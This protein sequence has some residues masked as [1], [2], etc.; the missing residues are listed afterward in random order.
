M[1]GG[2]GAGYPSLVPDSISEKDIF[3]NLHRK[4]IHRFLKKNKALSGIKTPTPAIE[5]KKGREEERKNKTKQRQLPSVRKKHPLQP[6]VLSCK[7]MNT[8]MRN[9]L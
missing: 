8:I 9:L 7:Q 4:I 3:I 6:M 2:G 5:G 1:T